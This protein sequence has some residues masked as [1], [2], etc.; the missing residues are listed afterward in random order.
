M[1]SNQIALSLPRDVSWVCHCPCGSSSNVE[2][3]SFHHQPESFSQG[4]FKCLQ[5]RVSS[6]ESGLFLSEASPSYFRWTTLRLLFTQL[7]CVYVSSE[8]RNDAVISSPGQEGSAGSSSTKG[9]WFVGTCTK[10]TEF[11]LG[12]CLLHKVQELLRKKPLNFFLTSII[13]T[14]LHLSSK[15]SETNCTDMFYIWT[16]S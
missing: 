13:L 3:K 10:G 8:N 16:F 7:K 5:E 14:S 12:S 11:L 4:D 15:L 9:R 2:A 1:K 6:W